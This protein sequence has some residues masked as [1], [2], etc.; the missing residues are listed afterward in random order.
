MI[1]SVFITN[2]HTKPLLCRQYTP[3]LSKAQL[4]SLLTT[5]ASLHTPPNS[6]GS[7][8]GAS[9]TT[10]N[11]ASLGATPSA[12]STAKS[13]SHQ[14]YIEINEFRF[15]FVR[16]E[17]VYLGL[18]SDKYSNIIE[19][20]D[21]LQLLSRVLKDT[22]EKVTPDNVIDF[23]FE[24]M[25]AFDELIS[26][27]YK[28]NLSL[29]QVRTILEMDSH[30]ENLHNLIQ[31]TR[32]EDAIKEGRKAAKELAAKKREYK[33]KG[34]DPESFRTG[35]SS[36]DSSH[37]TSMSGNMSSSG[38]DSDS[39]SIGSSAMEDSFNKRVG[40]IRSE[41]DSM[42]GFG[43]TSASNQ[44]SRQTIQKKAPFKPKTI[45][46]KKKGG[47]KSALVQ[48]LTETG[49]MESDDEEVETGAADQAPIP[50]AAV[51]L[52]Q[53]SVHVKVEEGVFAEVSREGGVNSLEVK[54]EM[55]LTIADPE[56]TNVELILKEDRNSSFT[57]KTH[58][59]IDKRR[60]NK[61]NIVALKKGKS[62]FPTNLTLKI[63][64]WRLQKEDEGV[65]PI[66]VSCWPSES[67][68]GMSVNVEYELIHEEMTLENV[69]I[70]IPLPADASPPEV[71]NV[72]TGTYKYDRHSNSLTWTLET[73]DGEHADGSIEF[74]MVGA[75]ND[76]AFFPLQ[77]SFTSAQ[78]L[79]GLE[80]DHV[81]MLDEDK[82]GEVEFSQEI[83]LN[84]PE[85][86]I[87]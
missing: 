30:E 7:G 62:N 13:S 8:A 16:C 54:G 20:L 61:E 50:E 63:L 87:A 23:S 70:K 60:F 17:D 48:Q 26:L 39:S 55:F 66:S 10:T 83:T 59:N 69:Q 14:S 38:F 82:E 58:P 43:S 32:M 74:D 78:T 6:S 40:S 12:T 34:L 24:V 25:F 56:K 85:Y 80:V 28:E 79:S 21:T 9:T 53:K 27:G 4:E 57:C 67:A 76:G 49:E 5:F 41:S 11:T 52:N 64:T 1:I 73:V 84:T 47:A 45:S 35:I 51:P 65:L 46:I 33:R 3:T 2:A 44:S 42:S 31:Q 77:I 22:I 75:S 19:D 18:I 37:I 36:R 72:E 29:D 68:K 15:V 81:N 71:S 86:S